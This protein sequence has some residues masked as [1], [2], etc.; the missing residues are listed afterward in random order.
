MSKVILLE[1]IDLIPSTEKTRKRKWITDILYTIEMCKTNTVG[2]YPPIKFHYG[3]SAGQLQMGPSRWIKHVIN[4]RYAQ[5]KARYI[6][7]RT[8]LQQYL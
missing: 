1:Y 2:I 6:F 8:F 3:T 4:K 5:K 7:V